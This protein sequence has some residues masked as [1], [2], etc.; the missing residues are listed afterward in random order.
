MQ[1]LGSLLHLLVTVWVAY[2]APWLFL[3]ALAGYVPNYPTAAYTTT[4]VVLALVVAFLGG[5]ILGRARA[6]RS[7]VAILTVLLWALAIA[8]FAGT[9]MEGGAGGTLAEGF[10]A[11]FAVEA[12]PL[13]LALGITFGLQIGYRF[14]SAFSSAAEPTQVNR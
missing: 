13:L 8:V 9:E 6:W 7:R 1:Q 14:M 11:D 5:A 3:G 2:I 10:V 4:Y 12:G